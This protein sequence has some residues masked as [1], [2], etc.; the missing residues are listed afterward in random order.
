MLLHTV[1]K[2]PYERN[3]F[4]SCLGHAVKG[5]AILFI[6][7]GVYA[8]V[9]GSTAAA[10]LAAAVKDFKVYV[11]GPDLLARG[12]DPANVVD[13]VEVVDYDGFVDLAA[14]HSAVQAWL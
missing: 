1:N 5:S 4:D 7:D 11:L 2:S 9:K 12:M 3:S 13:G 8:A 10:K 6:E 14:D